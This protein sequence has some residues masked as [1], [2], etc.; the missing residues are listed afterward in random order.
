MITRSLRSVVRRG[1][2]LT[3]RQIYART[4]R[5]FNDKVAGISFRKERGGENWPI[6]TEL[7][8]VVFP[9]QLLEN[10]LSNLKRGAGLI[11]N[12]LIKPESHWSFWSRVGKPS[13][14]NG[15]VEGRNIVDGELVVQVG[16]GLCQLSSLLHHL[17]LLGGWRL[18]SAILTA[19]I[20]IER[21]SASLLLEQTPRWYGGSRI[22]G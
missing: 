2:P 18:S 19:S 9:G 12:S 20:F 17:A 10:K 1:V 4:R 14:G 8:Q 6:R 7:T 13:A 11:D 15:F 21:M 16:G 3:V 5:R 22:C